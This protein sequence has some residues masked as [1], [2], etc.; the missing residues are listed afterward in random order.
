MRHAGTRNGSRMADEKQQIYW[1]KWAW[2]ALRAIVPCSVGMLIGVLVMGLAGTA[3]MPVPMIGLLC[4]L[5]LAMLQLYR[6]PSDEKNQIPGAAW[7]RGQSA[8]LGVAALAC[9]G[10]YG[11]YHLGPESK[12]TLPWVI[13][14]VAAGLAAI[15]IGNLLDWKVGNLARQSHTLIIL[16]WLA[17]FEL[18]VLSGWLAAYG[19]VISQVT[20]P[21]QRVLG[22]VVLAVVL[23]LLV[24]M[25]G[26]AITRSGN[27]SRQLRVP[28]TKKSFIGLLS[29]RVWG[30]S[31]APATLLLFTMSNQGVWF[32]AMAWFILLL[33]HAA[34]YYM[35]ISVSP[36]AAPHA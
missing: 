25:R 7:L 35:F 1:R 3:W 31:L 6:A 24:L 10:C 18:G 33:G 22:V 30:G 17:T 12:E 4:S 2:I 14:A 32:A 16:P 19:P 13:L 8:L 26:Y 21:H 23:E 29:L 27:M 20:A 11:A 36:Q 34:W 9:V 28:G 5:A 15:L